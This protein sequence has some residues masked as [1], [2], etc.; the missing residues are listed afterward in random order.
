MKSIIKEI[1]IIL[2][3]C[4]AICLIFGIV[5]Y[6]Y[7][8]NSK[9][10]PSTVEAYVTSN[11]IKDEISQEI[12]NYPKQN[13]TYEITNSDLTLY[14]ELDS[15]DQ[16]KANPFSVYSGDVENTLD[17]EVNTGTGSNTNTNKN[18]D[19]SDLFFNSTGLK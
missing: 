2:L 1:F 12:V 17:N 14:K 9:V 4:I 11:T 5:F 16:G 8:P 6:E 19:S 3:L 7:I 15:Y 18:P 13:Y 10:V